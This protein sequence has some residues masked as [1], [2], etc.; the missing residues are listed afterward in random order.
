MPHTA[1]IR[2][3]LLNLSGAMDLRLN[4]AGAADLPPKS[5]SY[6]FIKHNRLTK[7]QNHKNI[8]IN[9]GKKIH[10]GTISSVSYEVLKYIR[11]VLRYGR[12]K[13]VVNFLT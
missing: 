8:I 2:A 12:D 5:T 10:A 4:L 13:E 1:F 3:V 7:I 6:I 9:L 11:R